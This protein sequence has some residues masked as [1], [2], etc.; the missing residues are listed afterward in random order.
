MSFLRWFSAAL[1]FLAAGCSSLRRGAEA[2][3][4]GT[5]LS[6][7]QIRLVEALAHYGAAL[8]YEESSSPQTDR[9]LRH[10][11]EARERDPD[12]VGLYTHAAGVHLRSNQ[13]KKAV[14]L[15]EELVKNNPDD[16]A[17][18]VSLALTCLGSERV[19]QAITQYQKAIEIAPE[20]T[21]LYRQ[22]ASIYFQSGKK[23]AA[24]QLLRKGFQRDT[25]TNVLVSYC[26]NKGLQYIAAS[27]IKAAIACFKLVAENAPE[28][29][30]R[31]QEVLGELYASLGRF[32]NAASYLEKAMKVRPSDIDLA[33]KLASVHGAIS[34]EK[35]IRFLKA[36]TAELPQSFRLT[37][38]LAQFQAAQGHYNK[39]NGNFERARQIWLNENSNKVLPVEFY[40]NYAA[41]NEHA[42]KT[43]KAEKILRECLE[44]HPDSHEA[45]NFLAYSWAENNANLD[46]A[47]KYVKKALQAEPENGAYIDT[48]GWIHYK[49]GNLQK[50][51]EEIKRAVALMDE[52]P[53]LLEHLGDVYSAL[54]EKEKALDHWKKSF[55]RDPDNESLRRKLEEHGTD[56]GKL[57]KRAGNTGKSRKEPPAPDQE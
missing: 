55:L 13:N 15:L 56:I 9:A 12:N 48:L 41:V 46:K 23:D 39:A 57:K 32:R 40:L 10:L 5:S 4:R 38:R 14:E 54:G 21:E 3:H 2:E 8:I 11:E 28:R 29:R 19:D 44:E 43:G 52:D 17:A 37:Y 22:L 7:E 24:V 53:V 47:L 35:A 34:R 31:F 50:A 49:K 26:Y 16:V 20:K 45:L 18:R 30:D 1:L 25:D 27:R 42:D 33:L 6:D 51:L 36:R